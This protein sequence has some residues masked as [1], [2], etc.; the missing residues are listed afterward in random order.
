M[1][2]K[3]R[4]PSDDALLCT[5]SGRGPYGRG[6][7]MP[8]RD[9]VGT[10]AGYTLVSFLYFG[11]PIAN[12]PGRYEIGS[13]TDPNLFVWMF[14]WWP[15]AISLGVNPFHSSAIW[16]PGGYDLAWTTSVPGLA[17]IFA[18]LTLVAGPVV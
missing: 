7:H 17:V 11:L 4:G 9:T 16:V 15:H 8:R 5:A 14:A 1:E 18:P 13:G 6:V 3:P 12:H 2:G 10:L